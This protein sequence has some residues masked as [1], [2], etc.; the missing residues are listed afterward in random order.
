MS[1]GV[2]P[3]T[4]R[5]PAALTAL[6]LAGWIATAVAMQGMTSMDGPGA[7]GS[8]L[9]L[10]SAM[11][12]GMMLPALVP[13][14]MLAARVGRSSTGFVVG[15]LAVWA[16]TGVIAFV[17]ARELAGSASWIAAAA[18][19]V[20]AV[21]QLTPLKNACLSRCRGPLG[22][23]VRRRAVRA[24]I[25]HGLVC[26]G[27]C[28]ALMLALVALGAASLLWMAAVAAAIFLEKAT[29]LGARASVPIAL[30]LGGAAVWVAL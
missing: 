21:Y 18:I 27:C 16:A 22:L 29:S 28:W 2:V 7:I 5:I 26:L 15:Y 17:V 11:C 30:A 23:L 20:A 3:A 8:Y 4:L 13:A 14:A 6:A 19:A 25:E 9:W 1:V 10:W 24:G 12:A